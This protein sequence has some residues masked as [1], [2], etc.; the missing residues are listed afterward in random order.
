MDVLAQASSTATSEA[1]RG[2]GSPFDEHR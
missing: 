2:L 1:L